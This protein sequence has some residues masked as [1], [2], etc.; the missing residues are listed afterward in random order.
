MKR[1]WLESI[2]T[3]SKLTQKSIA[4]KVNI[5]RQYYGMIESGERDPS[6]TTAK[7]IATLLN[8]NWTNFFEH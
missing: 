8:F 4:D 3:K 2:R 5:S 7:K 1:H 6:V